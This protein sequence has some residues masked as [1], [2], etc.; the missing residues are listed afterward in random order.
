MF[1]IIKSVTMLTDLITFK[2]LTVKLLIKKIFFI[3]ISMTVTNV[4]NY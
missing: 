1:L 4:I 3:E 2:Q